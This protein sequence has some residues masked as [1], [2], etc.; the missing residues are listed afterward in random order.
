MSLVKR[1]P[2]AAVTDDDDPLARAFASSPPLSPRVT[3]QPLSTPPV[4]ASP[5]SSSPTPPASALAATYT[6]PASTYTPPYSPPTSTTTTPSAAPTTSS[7]IAA[8]A[9]GLFSSFTKAKPSTPSTTTS[10]LFT[11]STST[12]TSTLPSASTKSAADEFIAE[13]E[14]RRRER[15][16]T[17]RPSA[18]TFQ[19]GSSFSSTP[20]PL[21]P[22][23]NGGLMPLMHDS[24]PSMVAAGP[25]LLPYQDFTQVDD[26]LMMDYVDDWDSHGDVPGEKLIMKIEAVFY[27]RDADSVT[28]NTPMQS[29]QVA[30]RKNVFDPLSQHQPM[31][32]AVQATSYTPPTQVSGD[33]KSTLLGTLVMTSYQLYL[34]P[35]SDP[36]ERLAKHVIDGV[37]AM[38]LSTIEKVVKEP[39]RGKVHILD[40]HGKDGRVVRF[41]FGSETFAKRAFDC[42]NMFV[43][44]NQDDFVSTQPTHSPVTH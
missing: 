36:A 16:G 40:C 23:H 8:S 35:L 25:V 14:R 37:I 1:S 24:P 34:E 5:L 33:D 11:S 39:P 3:S 15:E 21:T 2:L 4:A 31:N 32:T 6:P 12:S 22:A 44:P 38:P 19:Q 26:D 9:R 43:F 27:Y 29:Q 18:I 20:N 13:A 10:S 17:V 41:G 42:L 7:S 30:A 28:A